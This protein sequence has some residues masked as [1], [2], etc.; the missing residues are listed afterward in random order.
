VRRGVV[1]LKPARPAADAAPD[2]LVRTVGQ[3]HPQR[4]F[5]RYSAGFDLSSRVPGGL[6]VAS[7]LMASLAFDG[8]PSASENAKQADL[9]AARVVVCGFPRSGTTFMQQAISR[10]LGSTAQCWKNHDVLAIPSYLEYGLPVLVP[11]RR[12]R[13]AVVSWSI[14]HADYPSV[15]AMTHRLH[16]YVAWHREF[17]R[18]SGDPGVRVI[19][20]HT[21]VADPVW[22]LDLVLPDDDKADVLSSITADAIVSLVDQDNLSASLDL[23]HGNTP[24]PDRDALKSAYHELLDDRRL[25]SIL[26]RAEELHE[27]LARHIAAD[28]SAALQKTAH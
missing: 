10:V 13:A 25:R 20:F 5:P 27:K 9:A 4:V 15:Q 24:H 3:F 14:Y 22:V 8:T 12:P 23:A 17:L 11:L 21:F 6:S 18:H 28:D 2:A 16:A 19:D 7:R 26:G 1:T